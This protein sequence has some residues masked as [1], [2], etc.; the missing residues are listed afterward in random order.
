MET[1]S[2][3]CRICKK[4]TK[5][6]LF[7]DLKPAED[8]GLCQCRTCGVMGVESLIGVKKDGEI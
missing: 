8:H 3:K 7:E 5:H 1:V 6:T 4:V 2:L